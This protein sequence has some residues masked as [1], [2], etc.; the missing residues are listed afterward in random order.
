MAGYFSAFPFTSYSGTTIKNITLRANIVNSFM[1]NA[2][3]FYPYTV[4]DGETADALAYD[5]Y[6]DANYIWIIYLVNNIIDPYYEWP[7]GTLDFDR[8][9]TNKYGS[10]AQAK[11]TT[12]YYKKLPVDYY[13]NDITNEFVLA[14]LYDP[15]VN[16]YGWTKYTVDE[17]IK[18]SNSTNPDPSVWQAVDAYTNELNINEQKRYIR[19]LDNSF[20]TNIDR[21]LKSILNG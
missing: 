20:V 9:I 17:D 3:N 11:T 21:Q 1:Q 18:I 13:V 15:S 8:F 12:A 4:K 6:G 7:L 14:S 16:G 5:Y 19:L 10:I 2:N